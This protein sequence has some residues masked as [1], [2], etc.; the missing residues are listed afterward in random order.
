MAWFKLISTVLISGA[1][2]SM[3]LSLARADDDCPAGYHKVGE[4][5]EETPT[6]TIIRSRCKR[7]TPSAQDVARSR[8]CKAQ[9]LITQD[10]AGLRALDFQSDVAEYEKFQAISEDQKASFEHKVFDAVLDQALEAAEQG[11]EVAKS[12]NPWSV[13]KSIKQLKAKGFAN[14]PL[15]AAMRKVAAATDKPAR[16]EAYKAF[17]RGFKV[18][19]EGADTAIDIHKEPEN[20]ELRLYLGALKIVQGNPE[21]GLVVTSFEFGES[22]SY[23][24]FLNKQIAEKNMLSGQKMSNLAKLTGNMKTHVSTLK[25]AQSDWQKA[26]GKGE[27]P[28]CDGL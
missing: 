22:F 17:V 2:L 1:L 14:E 4:D 8:Y 19:H 6:E 28:S 23:L 3:P 18:G 25:T 27:K 15:F 7:N 9:G 13:N 24:Y 26:G 16:V 10:Q 11:A 20:A 21:L 12:L 5:V